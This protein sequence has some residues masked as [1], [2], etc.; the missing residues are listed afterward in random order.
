MKLFF[1]LSLIACVALAQPVVTRGGALK[2][3]QYQTYAT[4]S[5]FVDPTGNDANACTATGTA[6]CATFAGAMAKVPPRVRHAVTVN[7]AAGTY[8]ELFNVG[9]RYIAA[10]ITLTVAGTMGSFTPA[11]GTNAGTTTGATAATVTSP[12]TITDSTQT[13][14]TNNLRGRYISFTGGTLSGQKFPIYSNTATSI[15]LA[16]S[17]SAGVGATYT[18]QTPATIFAASGSTPSRINDLTGGGTLAVTDIEI[19][20]LGAGTNFSVASNAAFVSLTRVRTASTTGTFGLNMASGTIQCSGCFI[21]STSSGAA[22]FN[23]SALPGASVVSTI[24]INSIFISAS[25]TT[26]ILLNNSRFSSMLAVILEA[27]G[28]GS[29]GVLSVG[30]GLLLNVSSAWMTCTATSS[31]GLSS[32]SG[33]PISGLGFLSTTACTAAGVSL[34]GTA[35]LTTTSVSINGA[36]TG[37]DLVRGAKLNLQLQ[38]PTFTGVT[39]ELSLDSVPYTYSFLSGLSPGVISNGFGSTIIK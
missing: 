10:N 29:T 28:D 35:T 32:A 23:G 15:V 21:S 4:M 16:N 37:F 7:I 8:A 19:S 39:N 27:R 1:L 13:W 9:D 3:R 36:A 20:S 26:A 25:N 34:S 31:T 6:A 22:T 14:T 18:I 12:A 30:N 11:T 38:T 17:A 33:M 24:L 5:L 2:R